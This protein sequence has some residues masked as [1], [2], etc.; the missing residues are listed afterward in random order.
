VAQGGK[1]EEMVSPLVK[2][3]IIKAPGEGPLLEG[4][5]IATENIVK[6]RLPLMTIDL[7]RR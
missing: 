7:T 1:G 4:I 3:I 6:K 2:D 5:E